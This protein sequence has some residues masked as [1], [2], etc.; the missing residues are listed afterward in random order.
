MGLGKHLSG[1]CVPHS[2]HTSAC[3]TVDMPVP[4]R[5]TI[6]MQQHMGAP[7][8]PC[9][10]VG[11]EVKVGQLIGDSDA[12]F[13]VPIHSS[14]S[15]KVAAIEDFRNSNGSVCPAVVID[16]D[17]EQT[18]FEGV[19][20][21]EHSDF[22][23]F[24]KAVKA[25]GLVGLGGAAF[26]TF[27]KLSP[28]NL[29]DVDTL[30]VNAAECE[31]YIT[32]DLRAMLEDTDAMISGI[33]RV[34][35]ELGLQRAIIGI[36]DNKPEAVEVLKPLCRGDIELAVLPSKYPKGGEK[37][38]IYE[39][40]GK[41]VPEGALPADVGVIVMNVS[42]IIALETYFSTGMPLVAKRLTVD[43]GAV[44]EP[45]NV[46]VPI[47]TSYAEVIEFC[48][49][50]KEEPKKIMMG[51]PMMGIAVYDDS[52]PVL[53][54]NNAILAFTEEES[55]LK[56]E[57]PCIRCG[58]CVRAC[59]FGLMPA[60]LDRAVQNGNTEE[61]AALKVNLCMECGCCAYVCPAGRPLVQSNRLGKALLRR[62]EGK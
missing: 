40:T 45:K 41:I 9:V 15:G 17:G 13:S 25:S 53:K 6:P 3:K 32:A 43:G 44:A 48:G 5:V 11:D 14:V 26:P 61:L 60:E 52:F 8:I 42:S 49:G 12:F 4:K 1:V 23:G 20:P 24:I 7:C 51:G 29:A 57:S 22:Q 35:R 62:K 50:Y 58:R 30:I 54:N 19:K 59:P 38:I 28:K 46:R 2:K 39:T 55:R 33:G 36:E 56:K 27:I 16:S 31:P 47:G 37:V 10:A 34:I 18:V 21:P